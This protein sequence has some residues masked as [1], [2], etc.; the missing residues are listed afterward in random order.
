MRA[1]TWIGLL[2]LGLI[3]A[4]VRVSVADAQSHARGSAEVVVTGKG[5][6]IVYNKPETAEKIAVEN[7]RENFEK[8]L[9]RRFGE[10]DWKV[11]T[12]ELRRQG[13]I[14]VGD[15]EPFVLD[16]DQP[17]LVVKE[18][19]IRVTHKFLQE[20]GDQ[21]RAERKYERQMVLARVLI[22]AVVLLLTV[23][24]YLRLEEATKG[25]YTWILRAAVV[26]VMVATG[27]AL[28]MS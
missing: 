13:L 23:A 16:K 15:A 20:L 3:A 24:G 26:G 7:A 4:A 21:A 2:M 25:Y 8:E 18:A 6:D 19:K 11:S 17:P 22:G 28:W 5:S 1:S 12:E 27:A 10:Y 9:T 14:E